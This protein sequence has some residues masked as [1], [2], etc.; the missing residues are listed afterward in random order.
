MQAYSDLSREN[1]PYA[2]PDVEVFQ[3]HYTEC[4]ECGD[5]VQ[6]WDCTTGACINDGRILKL[7][8]TGWFWW[9]CFPGCLP[10]SDAIGPFATEA[11]ALAD[12][13][14]SNDDISTEEQAY[15]MNDPDADAWY[16]R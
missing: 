12:A 7:T 4:P 11:E 10:D 8:E 13:Q 15:R 5:T 14:D 2:L 16:N 6:S 1:D 9:S 3:S